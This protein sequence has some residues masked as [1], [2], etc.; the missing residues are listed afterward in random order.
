LAELGEGLRCFFL[1]LPRRRSRGEPL[2]TDTVWIGPDDAAKVFG[3]N[4]RQRHGVEGF[5]PAV[6]VETDVLRLPCR[7]T[8]CYYTG[9][10][11]GTHG[12]AFDALGLCPGSVAVTRRG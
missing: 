9:R 2:F 1:T 12:N 7:R 4:R 11:G 10:Y 3:V 8:T 6:R 5:L